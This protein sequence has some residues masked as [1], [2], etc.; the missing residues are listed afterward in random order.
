MSQAASQATAFYR[1]VAEKRTLWTLRDSGGFPAPLK[2]N[3][4]RAQPFW[5]SRSRV[6]RI[7]KS[8]AAYAGFEPFEVTWEEFRDAWVT[9]LANDGIK[10]GVNWSG[11]AAVGYDLEPAWVV[12][13]VKAEIESHE[14]P[15]SADDTSEASECM[16]CGK[17]IPA[18]SDVCLACGWSYNTVD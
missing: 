2:P 15:E 10:V 1:E 6:E 13:A 17:V 12:R 18:N 4:E 7:V 8:V 11:K 5:S 14:P 3:G 16:Q 9:R